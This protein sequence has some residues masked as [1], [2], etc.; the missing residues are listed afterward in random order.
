V[1]LKVGKDAP[2]NPTVLKNGLKGIEGAVTDPFA[3][4]ADAAA[5]SDP[6]EN[7]ETAAAAARPGCSGLNGEFGVVLFE[8]LEV[9]ALVLNGEKGNGM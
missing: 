5:K 9:N 8:T 3:A 4:P 2:G 7:K 1:S 6:A